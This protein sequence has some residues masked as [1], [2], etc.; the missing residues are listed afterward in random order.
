[1]KLRSYHPADIVR[2]GVSCQVEFKCFI[3]F[4][5]IFQII[6]SKLTMSVTIP[7]VEKACVCFELKTGTIILGVINLV[8]KST[9]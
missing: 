9:E 1:M 3:L 4:V 8:W 2:Q 7:T 5:L 6:R